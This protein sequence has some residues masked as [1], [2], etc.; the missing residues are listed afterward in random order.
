MGKAKR[1][2]RASS[3]EPEQHGNAGRSF[4][5][6][7][8]GK[9][10]RK[11][12]SAVLAE[13]GAWRLQPW[14]VVLGIL[15]A[16]VVVFVVYQPAI[17]GP[18]LFDDNYLPFTHP[19]YKELPLDRWLIGVR[20]TLMLSFWLNYQV[21]KTEPF[22]YHVVNVV[23]HLGAAILVFFIVRKLLAWAQT[24][25]WPRDALA[26]FCGAVFLL[27]PLQTES[28]SYVASRSE[29][30]SV[31]LC[32]AA[33]AVFLYRRRQAIT[34]V[35]ALAVVALFGAAVTTKEHVVVL[36]ALLL[37]T[38]YYWNPGFSFQGIVRNWR[39]YAPTALAGAAGMVFILEKLGESDTAGFRVEGLSWYEYFLTQCKAIW[40]YLRMF[41]LPFGQNIDHDYPMVE[42]VADPLALAG[43]AGLLAAAGAAIWFRKRYPLMSYGF[44]VFLL[45]LAPTSSFV[46]IK[47]ALVERRIYLPMIGLLLIAA[48][49]LR[50]WKAGRKVLA[51]A[52]AAVMLAAAGMTLQRNRVW[53]APVPLWQDSV[54]KSPHNYRAN[55][56]LAYAY[57]AEHRCSEAVAQYARVAE[58]REPD[59]HLLIDWAL[60]C[61]CAGQPAE[62]LAK[63]EQAAALEPTAHVYSLIG[64]MHGKQGRYREA[65]EALA[66]AEK[67]DRYFAMTFF[68]RGNI[69]S[70]MGDNPRAIQEYR[71]A[72]MRDADNGPAIRALQ[73]L[74]GEIPK[75]R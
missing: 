32:Y 23:F 37:L 19:D 47:D 27:H 54:A 53:A 52:M 2:Q 10:P 74:G 51:A 20:P 58:L 42:S 59:A 68:Y 25:G 73:R 67:L 11:P 33:F 36:P 65:L 15:A 72:V 46:P 17:G 69:Y 39:L 71:E 57:Y 66:T 56:Q 61:D 31:F 48:D 9:P 26:A 35:E 30:L 3:S 13:A 34:F 16:A 55:F 70:A 22:T 40:I 38:D 6:A 43:L 60:A 62:A 50:R 41:L 21:S 18:F 64:M 7:A 14:R 1:R 28:V 29:N 5:P 49:L 24:D 8:K 44:L 4:A 12:A 45:L 75:P 63:L